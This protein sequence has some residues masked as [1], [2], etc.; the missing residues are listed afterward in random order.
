MNAHQFIVNAQPSKPLPCSLGRSNQAD[1]EAATR[2]TS[3]ELFFWRL[4]SQQLLA[5]FSSDADCA[6]AFSRLAS[7]KQQG[8]LARGFSLFLKTRVGPWLVARADAAAAGTGKAKQGKEAAVVEQARFDMLLRR[9]HAAEQ[10]L[11]RSQ[12]AVLAS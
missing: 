9:L 10:T 6:A 1:F 8:Q 5:S 3:K 2:W 7:Q 12:G 11:G 4:A